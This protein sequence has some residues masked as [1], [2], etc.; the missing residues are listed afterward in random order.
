M[1]LL[2]GLEDFRFGMTFIPN[3]G[4]KRPR[5][6]EMLLGLSLNYELPTTEALSVG[7]WAVKSLPT[8]R[9]E[10]PAPD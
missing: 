9:V 10:L 3:H 1:G 5:M 4:S 8:S 6:Q 7:S 2:R